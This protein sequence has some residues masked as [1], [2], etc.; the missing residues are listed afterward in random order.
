L[1]RIFQTSHFL[2]SLVSKLFHLPIFLLSHPQENKKR[3][4]DSER[5][6]EKDK[7]KNPLSKHVIDHVYGIGRQQH[8]R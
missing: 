7:I 6:R 1:Q 4:P 8:R 5:E 3:E 2:K